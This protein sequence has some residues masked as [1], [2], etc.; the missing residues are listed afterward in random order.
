MHMLLDQSCDCK[1]VL[2]VEI[3]DRPDGGLE[4][5]RRLRKRVKI[6]TFEDGRVCC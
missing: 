5:S 3:E 2:V 6:F 1:H 4:E